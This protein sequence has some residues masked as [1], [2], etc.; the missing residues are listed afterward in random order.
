MQGYFLI[1]FAIAVG[2]FALFAFMQHIAITYFFSAIL[3]L[4]LLV[5]VADKVPY[6]KG[7]ITF[8]IIGLALKFI[9]VLFVQTQ[10]TSDFAVMLDGARQ[11]VAGGRDYL[12]YIYYDRFP[13]Q[14]GFT[15]YQAIVLQIVNA[16]SALKLANIIWCAIASAAVYGIALEAF[17]R[18]V[19]KLALLLH[20]TLLPILM[21]SSVL[22]NQH[23][24]AAWFYVGIYVWL[25][26]GRGHWSAPLFAG[27]LI[28]VGSSL[29]PIGI[30]IIAAMIVN[31]LIVLLRE[32]SKAQLWQSVRIAASA[33]VSYQLI[34]LLIGAILMQ[35]GIS[36]DGLKNKD[37]LWKVVA[38]LNASSYGSYS[39]DDDIRLNYGKMDPD[40]RTEM[41]MDMIKERLADTESML[42][43][44]FLKIG[45]FWADYQPTWATFPGKEGSYFHY[46][47]WTV[48]FDDVIN[49]YRSFERAV[50][51][52]LSL[53]AFWGIWKILRQHSQQHSR[54]HFANDHKR[55]LILLLGAYTF[56]HLIIEVQARYLYFAMFIV[57]IFAAA[58]LLNVRER[59]TSRLRKAD[60]ANADISESSMSSETSSGDHSD[61]RA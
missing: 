20:V 28:A 36:P 54:Q 1:Y 25:K 23:V 61:N 10:A 29:R 2:Q 43:L 13:Y 60:S 27:A 9:W 34:L 14:L 47:G 51:Y 46:L 4:A 44:P 31:E 5:F 56:V 30:V 18:R 53:L 11:I 52:L 37:P 15:T 32:K 21:L 58:E 42:K 22:T 12:T 7:L 40:L 33:V 8:S 50:F 48:S 39:A 26:W 49:R 16:V 38:G 57:V 6:K 19:A 41:E 17:D 35:T 45:R 59:L 55:F 24:A 3:W